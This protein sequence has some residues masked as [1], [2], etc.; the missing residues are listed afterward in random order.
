MTWLI[1]GNSNVTTTSF[2]GTINPQP[3]VIKTNNKE[4]M[5][6]ASADGDVSIGELGAT[7]SP[8]YKLDVQGILNADDIYKGG[9]RLVGSQ[10]EDVTDDGISYGAGNVGIGE[11]GAAR[12]P[13]YKLDVQGILNAD[14]IYK[15]GTQ[16]VGSQWE[17][18]TDDGIS[19]GAGNVGIGTIPQTTRLSIATTTGGILVDSEATDSVALVLRSSGTGWGSGLQLS[20]TTARTGRNYGLY[21]GGDGSLHVVDATSGADR[22]LI[23]NDGNFG[24]GRSPSTYRLLVAATSVSDEQLRGVDARAFGDGTGP[25]YGISAIASGGGE[26]RAGYVQATSP[27]RVNT[28]TSGG[29]FSATGEGTGWKDGVW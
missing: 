15:D 18:V 21:A 11:L 5:R 14:D 7:R 10:W 22:L 29:V 4:A 20:N 23:N 27:A 1:G 2:L 24:I 19:Y 17:D 8:D 16:L 26:K 25:K 9:A 12:D 28:Y 3:L 6:V 13:D